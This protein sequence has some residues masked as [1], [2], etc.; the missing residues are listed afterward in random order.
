M[1]SIKTRR[2]TRTWR[3]AITVREDRRSKRAGKCVTSRKPQVSRRILLIRE[4]LIQWLNCSKTR[5]MRSIQYGS[6]R[7]SSRSRSISLMLLSKINSLRLFARQ[8]ILS[9]RLHC[10]TTG[11]CLW[12]GRHYL[13]TRKRT[14]LLTT[15]QESRPPLRTSRCQLTTKEIATSKHAGQKAL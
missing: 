9:S 13:D 14:S 10:M 3:E 15:R 5:T 7:I 2:S 1:E 8:A 6:H 12:N 11:S 4:S